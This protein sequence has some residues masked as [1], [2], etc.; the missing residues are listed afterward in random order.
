[1]L[2]DDSIV[3]A[4]GIGTISFQRESQ[5]PMSVRDVLFVSRLKKNLILVS[6]IEDRRYEAVFRDG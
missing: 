6:T 3:R 1:M 5:P 4:V 2:G